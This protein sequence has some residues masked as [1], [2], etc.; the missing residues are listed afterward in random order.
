MGGKR[1]PAESWERSF[2]FILL[3]SAC[4]CPSQKTNKKKKHQKNKTKNTCLLTPVCP[5]SLFPRQAL[6][7]PVVIVSRGVKQRCATHT[8]PNTVSPP[9]HCYTSMPSLT[10]LTLSQVCVCVSGIVLF[11]TLRPSWGFVG[12]LAPQR[13][14][15][16]AVV[17][18]A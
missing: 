8:D 7:S 6:I 2:S 10:R 11:M 13:Q 5:A 1:L 18:R 3:V 9:Q 17:I 4:V 12:H 16:T 15:R 14:Q